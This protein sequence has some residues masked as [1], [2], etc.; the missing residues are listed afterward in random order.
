MYEE[1]N[2]KEQ[3]D[4]I[5]YIIQMILTCPMRLQYD[6]LQDQLEE[7]QYMALDSEDPASKTDK[8]TNEFIP[9]R[10]IGC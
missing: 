6:I 10:N 2:K 3:P 9:I 4:T 5:P 1:M 8:E 7:A